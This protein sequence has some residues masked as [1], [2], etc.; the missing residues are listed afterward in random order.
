MRKAICLLVMTLMI[1][2]AV[3]PAVSTMKNNEIN[4]EATEIAT[5][6]VPT[7][8]SDGD[9]FYKW[10]QH[11]DMEW[12]GIDIRCDRNDGIPRCIA[13]DFL[14]DQEG[15]IY[16]VHFWGSWL[17]DEKGHIEMIHLSIHDDVP[18]GPMGWSTPGD[19]LW[20]MDFFPG[21][22]QET[23]FAIVPD[24]EW[25]WD[26][27]T[28]FLTPG[29]DQMIW[30]YD[31]DIPI[32]DCFIQAGTPDEPIVYWLDIW[33]KTDYGEF[34]WKTSMDHWN[35]DAV[36]WI[37]DQPWWWVLRYPEP[38]PFHPESIDM[39]FAITSRKGE[40]VPDTFFINSLTGG[41]VNL[42][43]DSGAAHAGEKYHILGSGTGTT[44]GTPL[45]GGLT[46]P[47]NWDWFTDFTIANANTWIFPGFRGVLDATGKA[48]AAINAPPGAAPPGTRLYFAGLTYMPYTFVSDPIPIDFI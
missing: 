28:G 15:P 18:Q 12:T 48:T 36:Y 42:Q 45:P 35:D 27:Y 40:L 20:E 21:Q 34:G 17:W 16:D 3:L 19:L 22:F 13:D 7:E 23:L 14:C 11:P 8:G 1:A 9:M 25:F 37:D 29:A 39:S 47:L 38:H 43:V 30:Q 44:P 6:L 4:A 32:E 31:I 26:P 2:A 10:M 33:V 24:Y 46:L 5:A 41:T